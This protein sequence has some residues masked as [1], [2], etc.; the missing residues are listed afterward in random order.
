MA[1]RYEELASEYF[2]LSPEV[3]MPT[4]AGLRH[5]QEMEGEWEPYAGWSPEAR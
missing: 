5:L 3:R 1:F 2:A 4:V